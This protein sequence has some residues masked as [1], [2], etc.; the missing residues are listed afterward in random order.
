MHMGM[1]RKQMQFGKFAE[2]EDGIQIIPLTLNLNLTN[3]I[4]LFNYTKQSNGLQAA[5]VWVS[6]DSQATVFANI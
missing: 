4:K 1:L 6:Y 5:V 3:Q 2:K